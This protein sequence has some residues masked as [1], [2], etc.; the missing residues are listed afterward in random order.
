MKMGAGGKNSYDKRL[1]AINN[2][3]LN[4]RPTAGEKPCPSKPETVMYYT[5]RVGQKK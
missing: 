5:Y 1:H 2:N 4:Y 3:Y